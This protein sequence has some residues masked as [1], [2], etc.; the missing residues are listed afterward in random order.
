MKILSWNCRGLD[1]PTA[2]LKCKKRA[3]EFKLDVMFLME[4]RL[5]KE[6]G[7]KMYGLNVGLL[8]DGKF[9]GKA[10]EEGCF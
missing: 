6:K 3:L 1:K 8:R 10:W 2:V 5:V 7:K 4:P 9:L